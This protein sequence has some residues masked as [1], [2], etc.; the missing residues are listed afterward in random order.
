MRR[1][2]PWSTRLSHTEAAIGIERATHHTTAALAVTRGSFCIVPKSQNN[3]QIKVNCIV[4][5]GS[6]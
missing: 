2:A 3:Q 1:C 6:W 4:A 5:S